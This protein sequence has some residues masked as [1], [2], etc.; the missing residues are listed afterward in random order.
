MSYR[1]CEIG[2]LFASRKYTCIVNPFQ[3]AILM[4]FNKSSSYTL[5]KIRED[6]RLSD[7]TLKAHLIP[8]FNPKQKLL[9]KQSSGK[10]LGD[11]EVIS[12]NMDFN[13]AGLRISFIPKKVKKAETTNREDEKAVENERKYILSSVI[14]RI[15]K[16][17][18]QIMHQELITEV[19]RQ[20]DLFK[21]QP[22]M[23]NGQIESLIEREFLARD[24]TNKSL[25]I[26]LP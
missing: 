8:F 3:A 21:P 20:V 17:R 11:E 10:T 23:I 6:T 15:A 26:Y 25:Y 16:G 18:R 19:F 22:H 13:S 14:V 4:L 12:L 2:T 5:S 9:L 7:N 1:T 24:E